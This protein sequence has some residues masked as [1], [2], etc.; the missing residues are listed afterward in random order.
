MA[1]RNGMEGVQGEEGAENGA[2]R[3]GLLDFQQWIKQGCQK[4]RHLSQQSG[5]MRRFLISLSVRVRVRVVNL[6]AEGRIL[7]CRSS[8]SAGETQS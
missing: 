7:C 6:N 2:E 5:E 1:G 8:V 4:S 3:S